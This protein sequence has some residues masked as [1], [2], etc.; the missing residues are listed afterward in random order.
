MAQYYKGNLLCGPTQ[1]ICTAKR[2]TPGPKYALPTLTGYDGHDPEANKTRAPAYSL[3]LR[4]RDG[5]KVNSPGPAAYFPLAKQTKFGNDGS[6]AYSLANRHKELSKHVSPGPGAY[7]PERHPYPPS[8]NAPGFSMGQ[9]LKGRKYDELFNPGPNSYTLP[10]RIGTAHPDLKR[11]PAY[12]I[13]FRDK[14]GGIAY[15]HKKTPGPAAYPVSDQN[16]VKQAAPEYS[17]RLR[18]APPGDKTVK[19]GPA[20]HRPELC[21]PKKSAPAFSFGS[22]HHEY[23]VSPIFADCDMIC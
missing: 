11:S 17:M 1:Y 4:L 23:S 3:R 9:R 14:K 7:A 20:S 8:R 16:K 10:S 22:R 6:P 15:D 2:N 18:C 5:N 12:F 13:T 21:P 19:P